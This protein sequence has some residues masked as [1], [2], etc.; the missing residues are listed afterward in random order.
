MP[1]AVMG[2]MCVCVGPPDS[3]VLGS[4]GVFFG[5]KPAA[6][7]GDQCAHGGTITLGC[8]TVLVGETGAG[9]PGALCMAGMAAAGAA[10]GGS[11]NA[12]KNSVGAGVM[13]NVL[14]QEA[15]VQGAA[16]G[17]GLAP[18]TD[19]KDLTAQFTLVDEAEKPM[20]GKKYE[21][22]TSDGKKYNGQ[23]DGS[24]KTSTVTGVTPADCRVTFF[25]K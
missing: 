1:A 19:T 12:L 13:K 17:D 7:M 14:N 18:R 5:G 4:T 20:E 9:S 3:V 25:N 15:L 16:A 10:A 24:G 23:T 11:L 2:D 6:R 8:P 22:E 21:I